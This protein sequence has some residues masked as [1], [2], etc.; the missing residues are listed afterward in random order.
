[1]IT[2]QPIKEGRSTVQPENLQEIIDASVS[3]KHATLAAQ[4]QYCTPTVWASFFH[5]LLPR[6]RTEYVTF[7]PQC[8]SGNLL[9]TR[10]NTF[11]GG[12]TMGFELDNRFREQR[13]NVNRIIGKAKQADV[14]IM[15]IK[16][17]VGHSFNEC[18][19]LIVGSLEYSFGSL[20]QAR[21]RVFRVNSKRNIKI[22]CVL[23]KDTIE[24]IIFDVVAVKQDAATICLH[25]K[26]IPR[27]FKPVDMSEVLAQTIIGFKG[28]ALSE[29]ECE[30]K[31]PS[32][33][34]LF[35]AKLAA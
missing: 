3:V 1:M 31:W 13:D 23:H 34:S 35:G 18:P 9:A 4:Q 14:L 2:L 21:G 33:R 8:A 27:D 32:L 24:E 26:R 16:C 15:G 28:E 7:D 10:R 20:H 29:R 11:S 30:N 22:Y 17:A 12:S 5:T 25:G 6:V 19:N